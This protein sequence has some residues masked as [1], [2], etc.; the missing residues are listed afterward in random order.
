M[1]SAPRPRALV[2]FHITAAGRRE[3][4]H[5]RRADRAR[6]RGVTVMPVVGP[7]LVAAEVGRVGVRGGG[8]QR[9]AAGVVDPL[10]ADRGLA[11]REGGRRVAQ[12]GAPGGA[13]R[14]A[15][16]VIAGGADVDGAVV[17]R[18][19][20]GLHVERLAVDAGAVELRRRPP[21]HR[22]AAAGQAQHEDLLPV[23]AA[24]R[25]E[26][27][28]DQVEVPAVAELLVVGPGRLAADVVT[29]DAQVDEAI[30]LAGRGAQADHVLV[31]AAIDRCEVAAGQ[32]VPVGHSH[33]LDLAVGAF[34]EGV[35]DL[36]GRRAY[37]DDVPGAAAVHRAEIAAQVGVVA[38]GAVERDGVHLAIDVRIPR[39]HLVRRGRAEAERVMPAV[40][41]AALLDRR[42]GADR[43]H[44]PAALHELPDLLGAPGRCQLGGAAGRMGGHRAARGKRGSGQPEHAGCDGAGDEPGGTAPGPA[45]EMHRVPPWKEV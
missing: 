42:E 14:P 25:G 6:P 4:D 41:G 27:A 43:V 13:D 19:G 35:V 40:G 12:P 9:V 38:A 24:D 10:V 2:G 11:G 32:Q 3:A 18:P 7:P 21:G 8:E 22:G 28:L 26:D 31:A 37:L 39:R 30:V 33:G 16:R 36:A 20:S 23:L 44:R 1:S 15:Q 45:M 5:A 17:R 34:P 29:G